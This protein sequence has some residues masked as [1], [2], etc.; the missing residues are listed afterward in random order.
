MLYLCFEFE[1][2]T[3]LQKNPSRLFDLEDSSRIFVIVCTKTKV[4]YIDFQTILDY[5]KYSYNN[6]SIYPYKARI[7]MQLQTYY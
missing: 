5:Y 4:N 3:L 2:V 1:A 6:D 7:V